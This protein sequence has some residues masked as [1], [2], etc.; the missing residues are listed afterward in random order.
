MQATVNEVLQISH[1]YGY[2]SSF[3]S[4]RITE[5]VQRM[6]DEGLQYDDAAKV[7]NKLIAEVC[8]VSIL[9]LRSK[10]NAKFFDFLAENRLIYA[11]LSGRFQN[12]F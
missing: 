12:L 4:E 11:V 5:C 6:W 8:N 7:L 9:L 2:G 3:S 1:S 10:Q